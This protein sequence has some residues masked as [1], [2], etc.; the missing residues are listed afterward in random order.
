[1]AKEK[2]LFQVQ[3]FFPAIMNKESFVGKALTVSSENKLGKFDIL[4]QHINF[5]S[6][7]F[8]K[9]TI[10]TPEKEKI[11]YQF[12]KGVLIVKKSKVRVFLGL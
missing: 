2:P 9:L 3:V 6:L 12:K 8:N 5:I 7:I 10:Q 11:D 4:P 1:M